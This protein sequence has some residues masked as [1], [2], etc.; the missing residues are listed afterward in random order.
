MNGQQAQEQ[1][2]ENA[3]AKAKAT[4]VQVINAP[5]QNQT[6]N[7][8]SSTAAVM[9]NNLPTVDNNDRSWALGF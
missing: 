9:D 8:S 2:K 6:V 4:A 7:N 1:S 3:Q 5:Q